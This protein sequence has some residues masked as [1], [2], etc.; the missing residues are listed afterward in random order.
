MP[1]KSIVLDPS[2]SYQLSD[3]RSLLQII[4]AIRD[5]IKY[6]I[7]ADLAKLIP[8]SLKEWADY[9]H[10]HERTLARYKKAN[11]TFDAL[12]S[13]RIVQITML[14]RTGYLVFG[15]RERFHTWLD[16]QN[17]ALGGVQPKAL[18]DNSMGIKMI[19][20]ELSRIEHGVLA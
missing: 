11:K 13:D 6:S 15:D 20:D 1:H 9:L 10:M 7:F 2:I 17:L 19:E 8:L 12:Y 5:G 3:D 18:L 4:S 16:T 14:Y